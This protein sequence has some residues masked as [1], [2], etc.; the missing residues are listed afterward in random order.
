MS[1]G[2]F[3]LLSVQLVAVYGFA[4]DSSQNYQYFTFCFYRGIF[5]CLGGEGKDFILGNTPLVSDVGFLCSAGLRGAHAP[6]R[7]SR[8]VILT[9]NPGRKKKRARYQLV[10]MVAP[11]AQ[12][13]GTPQTEGFVVKSRPKPRDCFSAA[14]YSIQN[15][16]PSQGSI[17]LLH[18]RKSR[19]L[20][21][22][23]AH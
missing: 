13:A 11:T 22:G 20:L 21:S 6:L 12:S 9:P 1:F 2:V 19:P 7:A 5:S 4:E 18:S 15:G 3:E 16:S 23:A 14:H 10:E 17:R 8:K